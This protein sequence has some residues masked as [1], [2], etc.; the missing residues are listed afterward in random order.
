[1]FLFSLVLYYICIKKIVE[2]LKYDT[3]MKTIQYIIGFLIGT[4]AIALLLSIPLTFGL[5][6]IAI[7][8]ST[9]I[10]FWK[11]WLVAFGVGI[12]FSTLKNIP[13]LNIN[14]RGDKH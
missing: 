3:T 12:V 14:T 4:F 5:L 13:K 10:A 7:G 2:Q 8:L 9:S 11:I 6:F 1:M